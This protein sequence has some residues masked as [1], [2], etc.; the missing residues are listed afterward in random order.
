MHGPIHDGLCDG[1]TNP[2]RLRAE[3]EMD[4][5]RRGVHPSE[6]AMHHRG[7]VPFDR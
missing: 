2:C 4:R 5:A 3:Q 1:F 7:P 6:R